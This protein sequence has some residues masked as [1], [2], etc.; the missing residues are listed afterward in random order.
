MVGNG[1]DFSPCLATQFDDENGGWVALYKEAVFLL[2]DILF[3][4]FQDV[5]VHQLNG[6]RMEF[7]C[8]EIA[9]ETLLQGVAMGADHHLLFGWQEVEVDFDFSDESQSALAAR[10]DLTEVDGAFLK[11]FGRIMQVFDD[12]VDSVAT[13]TAAQAL[14]GVVFFYQMDDFFV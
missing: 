7:Q 2:L 3:A 8:N 13:G 12:F 14:V 1:I 6:R 11:W 10:Q 4:E 5:A 9:Q